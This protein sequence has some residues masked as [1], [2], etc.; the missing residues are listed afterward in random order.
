[1]SEGSNF[2]VYD[3]TITLHKRLLYLDNSIEVSSRIN[4]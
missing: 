4:N 2:L 1:M 3:S